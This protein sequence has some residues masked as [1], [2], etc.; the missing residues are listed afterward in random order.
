M[1]KLCCGGYIVGYARVAGLRR[2]AKKAKRAVRPGRRHVQHSP[3]EYV[4]DLLFFTKANPN[5]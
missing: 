3:L 4:E 5:L 1:Q 2:A